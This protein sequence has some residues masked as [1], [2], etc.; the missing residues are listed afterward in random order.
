M[1]AQSRVAA[2]RSGAAF[3]AGR[4]ATGGDTGEIGRA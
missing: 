4:P 2:Q 3:P 1:A